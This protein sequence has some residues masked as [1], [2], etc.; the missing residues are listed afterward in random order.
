MNGFD[1]YSVFDEF[2]DDFN[3]PNEDLFTCE[4]DVT[5]FHIT[6]GDIYDII[7]M[8]YILHDKYPCIGEN[9]INFKVALSSIIALMHYGYPGINP[10][11]SKSVEMVL[12]VQISLCKKGYLDPKNKLADVLSNNVH[13][14]FCQLSNAFKN[15]RD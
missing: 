11:R 4:N 14:T 12:D 13:V 7:K 2:G 3:K 10:A 5:T 15:I 8:M 1:E 9:L 6:K